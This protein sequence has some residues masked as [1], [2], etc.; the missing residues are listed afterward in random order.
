MYTLCMIST[1]FM[2]NTANKLIISSHKKNR[3]YGKFL[4]FLVVVLFS[5]LAYFRDYTI[6]T[7]ISYYVIPAFQEAKRHSFFAYFYLISHL[8]EPIYLLFNYLFAAVCETPRIWMFMIEFIISSLVVLRLY[9]YRYDRKM[10]VGIFIFNC[11]FLP[12]SFN[13]MRQS[14]AMAIIF[15]ASRYILSEKKQIVKYIII[16]IIS[17]GFHLTGII[18]M[19][20]PALNIYYNKVYLGKNNKKLDSFIKTGL[21]IFVMILSVIFFNQLV[22]LVVPISKFTVKYSGYVV[23]SSGG[24]QVNPLLVRIP[25]IILILIN[26]K[27]YERDKNEN[28][29]LFVIMIIDMIMS[30]LRIYSSTLYRV[31]IYFAYFKILALPN[32]LVSLNIKKRRLATG[33]IIV[34]MYIIWIYQIVIQGN[35]QVFPYKTF[36][37]I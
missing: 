21:I 19:L 24:I 35:E 5:L 8:I 28:Y 23:K 10:W 14:I 4:L 12:I 22:D 11:M 7:D 18:G 33:L 32:Y 16:I 31:S 17:M 2:T 27:K 20:L 26:W 6:G 9:D 15:Y 37:D 30:E 34:L 29:M 3:R 25:F 36:F 1:C 13:L